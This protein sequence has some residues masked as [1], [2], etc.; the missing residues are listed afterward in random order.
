MTGELK[1]AFLGAH[2][3]LLEPHFWLAMQERHAAGEIMDIFPYRREQR[4]PTLRD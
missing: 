2:R 1:K 4:F 3:D